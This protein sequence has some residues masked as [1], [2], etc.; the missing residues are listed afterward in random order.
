MS[1][2]LPHS[3]WHVMEQFK[4][5]CEGPSAGWMETRTSRYRESAK[6]STSNPGP[7]LAEEQGVRMMKLDAMTE[8]L[9]AYGK[10]E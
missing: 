6:P 5:S 2:P 10:Y 4:G 1:S 9:A 8:E 3:S 7:M